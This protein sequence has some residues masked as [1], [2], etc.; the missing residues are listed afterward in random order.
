MQGKAA[1]IRP[2]V[3][4]P[5]PEPYASRSYMHRAALSSFFFKELKHDTEYSI[6]FSSGFWHGDQ[7]LDDPVVH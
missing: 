2:K 3:V 7:G 1:Y 4:R 6:H 5:F